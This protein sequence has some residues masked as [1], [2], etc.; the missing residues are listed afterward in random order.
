MSVLKTLNAFITKHRK[1]WCTC[2]VWCNCVSDLQQVFGRPVVSIFRKIT[3]I[4]FLVRLKILQP[5][6]ERANNK[7]TVA[8]CF[9]PYSCN[10]T[11]ILSYVQ[12]PSNVTVTFVIAT[13]TLLSFI[14]PTRTHVR[15]NF[16][17]VF[18]KIPHESPD[19]LKL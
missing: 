9:I 7:T 10:Y 16:L 2:S 12:H 3:L 15:R 6:G 13:R 4:K 8:T 1:D 19:G 5:T 18:S 14:Q 11:H 17:L